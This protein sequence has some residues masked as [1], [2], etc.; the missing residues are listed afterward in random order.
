MQPII[1]PSIVSTRWQEAHSTP[2]MARWRSLSQLCASMWL[3][4]QVDAPQSPMVDDLRVLADLA[5][6][7]MLDMQ[8]ARI[9]A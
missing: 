6:Q 7:H 9:A 8:P 5:H 2:N 4:C 1:I 3:N